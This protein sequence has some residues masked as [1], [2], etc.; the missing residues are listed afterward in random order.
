MLT[1]QPES[2][3]AQA[4]ASGPKSSRFAAS[5]IGMAPKCSED[6]TTIAEHAAATAIAM[7]TTVREGENSRARFAL[8]PPRGGLSSFPLATWRIPAALPPKRAD[9][10]KAGRLLATSDGPQ[11]GTDE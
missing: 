1:Y 2:Q 10:V 9:Y 3:R 7:P 4:R 8:T 11:D 5:G 6:Q